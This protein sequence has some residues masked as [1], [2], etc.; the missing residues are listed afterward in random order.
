MSRIIYTKPMET[1]SSNS[2]LSNSKPRQTVK[3]S[4]GV[5]DLFTAD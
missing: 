3:K 4:V 1:N 5:H 2:N